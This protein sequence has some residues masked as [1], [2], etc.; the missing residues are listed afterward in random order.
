MTFGKE[1]KKPTDTLRRLGASEE[2]STLGMSD[3]TIMPSQVTIGETIPK[4]SN[5][6]LSRQ[7]HHKALSGH[8]LQEAKGEILRRKICPGNYFVCST[9]KIRAYHKNVPSYDSEAERNCRS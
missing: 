4:D 8:R 7:E 2:D 1:G 6:T 3:Q 9:V 5:T